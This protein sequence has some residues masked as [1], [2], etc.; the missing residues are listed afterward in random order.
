MS[1]WY[2]YEAYQLALCVMQVSMVAALPLFLDDIDRVNFCWACRIYNRAWYF[3]PVGIVAWLEW[4]AWDRIG[5]DVSQFPVAFE[6]ELFI[7]FPD[8]Y[9]AIIQDIL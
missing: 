9:D 7:Y 1:G 8:L 6:E 5:G 4:K 3:E 2:F